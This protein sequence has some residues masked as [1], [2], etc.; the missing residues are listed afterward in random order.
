[1]SE[2]LQ[3]QFTKIYE[4]KSL[5][6][7]VIPNRIK[8][9]FTNETDPV[10]QHYLF[11]GSSG[12]GKSSLA[13]FLASKYNYLYVNASLNA[14]IDFLRDTITEFCESYQIPGE[15]IVNTDRKIIIL[16]EL[17]STASSDVFL[18]AIKGF[19]DSYPNA[20][21]IVT[22]NHFNKIP[23]PI[24]SRFK[25]IN[26]GFADKQEETLIRGYY[27][28]RISLIIS[29][30]EIKISDESLTKL[31]D[32]NFPD[33]RKALNFLQSV[34]QSGVKEI[35]LDS[36][37]DY[38]VRFK[39]IYGLALTKGLSP[40]KIHVVVN[41]DYSGNARDVIESIGNE[42]ADYII[43]EKSAFI[44]TLPN[45]I[46]LAAKYSN[47]MNNAIDPLLCL[48]ACIYEINSLMK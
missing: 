6:S 24:K 38:D 20:K 5:N 44:H 48:K 28:K 40:E 4:P 2:V 25:C 12:L 9:E 17:S 27:R 8:Q 45:V 39:D 30:L 18:E 26:F 11:Y 36:I 23:D 22:T 35:T 19:M 43:K 3:K 10:G 21:F 46:V 1:M 15:N 42:F 41:M 37:K 29:K 13:K 16:D 33:F 47:M 31:E 7:F 14:R 32:T 34:H